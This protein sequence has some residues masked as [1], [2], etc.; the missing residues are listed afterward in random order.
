MPLF[1]EFKLKN[2]IF[3]AVQHVYPRVDKYVDL[4]SYSRMSI[5]VDALGDQWFPKHSIHVGE[6]EYEPQDIVF[7]AFVR[8]LE[9]TC[10]F[11]MRSLANT[12]IQIAQ[13][14]Y[15][16]CLHPETSVWEKLLTEHPLMTYNDIRVSPLKRK[17]YIHLSTKP[18]H[19]SFQFIKIA[20]EQKRRFKRKDKLGAK[21][22]I[23]Q[24]K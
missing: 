5:D 18:D 17:I 1:D 4:K 3:R 7:E 23:G 12:V 8:V 21:R 9:V 2:P 20:R 13:T 10:C 19:Y 11:D 16:A 15:I 14:I 6:E 22:Y 24:W